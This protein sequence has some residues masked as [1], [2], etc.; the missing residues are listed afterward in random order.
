MKGDIHTFREFQQLS[1]DSI[2][3]NLI[4]QVE[5]IREKNNGNWMDILKIAFKANP[6]ETKAVLKK[7]S[8]CDKGINKL[9]KELIE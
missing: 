9:F 2:K 6:K 8:E 3:E 1:E 5:S 4:S 7:I